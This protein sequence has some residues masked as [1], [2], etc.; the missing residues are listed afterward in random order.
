MKTSFVLLFFFLLLLFSCT[1]SGFESSEQKEVWCNI[2]PSTCK[3]ISESLC[4]DIGE[5]VLSPSDEKCVG[6][7]SSYEDVSSSSSRSVA[8]SS[9]SRQISSSSSRVGSSSSGAVSSSSSSG[10]GSSSSSD[11]EEI[12]SSSGNAISSSSVGNPSSSSSSVVSSSSIGVSSSSSLGRADLIDDCSFPSYVAKGRKE[13]IKNMFKLE[14]NTT[15]CVDG[16]KYSVS[17]TTGGSITGVTITGTDISFSSASSTKRDLKINASIKCGTRDISVGCPISVIVADNYQ[18][19]VFCS[20]SGKSAN[21]SIT[22][23]TVFEYRCD[24]EKEDYYIKCKNSTGDAEYKLSVN[25][26]PE[27]NSSWGGANLPNIK[28]I[29]IDEKLFYYPERVLITVN[30]GGTYTCESW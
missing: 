16:I 23:T 28:P 7:S 10:V 6:S 24:E 19:S 5:P 22:G 8:G 30:G 25:G 15:E 11:E 21:L 17:S 4:A 18:D 13:S 27:A 26:Y 9:S 29:K 2:K 1:H 20:G 3:K 14:G 12:S